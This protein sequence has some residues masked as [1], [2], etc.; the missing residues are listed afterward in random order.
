MGNINFVANVKTGCKLYNINYNGNLKR[1]NE[2]Q[3]ADGG[4]VLGLVWKWRG[5]FKW[6]C[7]KFVVRGGTWL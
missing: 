2:Y 6:M 3:T 5:K 1:G 7:E 4:H